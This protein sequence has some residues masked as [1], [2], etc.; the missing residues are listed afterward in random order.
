M[1]RPVT[2]EPTTTKRYCRRYHAH[3]KGVRQ[4]HTVGVHVTDGMI[5]AQRQGNYA[6][7][8]DAE[9]MADMLKHT[10]EGHARSLSSSQRPKGCRTYLA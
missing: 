4:A 7:S 1:S 9:R 8:V 5:K 10:N 3:P 6:L 2:A